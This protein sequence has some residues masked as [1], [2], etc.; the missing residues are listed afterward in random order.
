MIHRGLFQPR[1]FCDSV[2]IPC[3]RLTIRWKERTWALDLVGDAWCVCVS[4]P[5]WR[6]R[7]QATARREEPKYSSSV[8]C[9]PCT[10]TVLRG[11]MGKRGNGRW[12]CKKSCYKQAWNECGQKGGW[13]GWGTAGNGNGSC[14][15]QLGDEGLSSRDTNTATGNSQI[16]AYTVKK[17]ES[18]GRTQARFLFFLIYESSV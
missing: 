2:K 15:L 13:I 17:S 11:L 14:S 18:S 6:P 1:T 3:L 5:W 12:G 4:I 8:P 7:K 16:S 9:Q 10:C